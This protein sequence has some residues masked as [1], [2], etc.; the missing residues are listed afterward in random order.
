MALSNSVYRFGGGREMTNLDP[1]PSYT[2]LIDELAVANGGDG[3]HDLGHDLPAATV[4][5][6][7]R[8]HQDVAGVRRSPV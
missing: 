7:S 3:A 1:H 6:S 5:D 2:A 4:S 8:G